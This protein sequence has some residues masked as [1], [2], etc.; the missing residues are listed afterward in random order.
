MGKVPQV[1]GHMVYYKHTH[2]S[3]CPCPCFGACRP[4]G[5]TSWF[6]DKS[7]WSVC[8]IP[9]DRACSGRLLTFLYIRYSLWIVTEHECNTFDRSYRHTGQ[10]NQTPTGLTDKVT[11]PHKYDHGT[12]WLSMCCEQMPSAAA[13]GAVREARG[14]LLQPRSRPPASCRRGRP[15]ARRGRSPRR[16]W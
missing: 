7:S 8:T 14:G 5:R 2:L 1:F 11:Q 4:P 6:E 12:M 9:G 3:A 13:P 10:P 16:C 15:A